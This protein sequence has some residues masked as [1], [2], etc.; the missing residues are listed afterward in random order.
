MPK[1]IK[2]YVDFEKPSGGRYQSYTVSLTATFA[3]KRE[4]EAFA[5]DLEK[6]KKSLEI[7][8]G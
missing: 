2:D 8:F 1:I 7:R 4:A 5:E 3:T 6:F